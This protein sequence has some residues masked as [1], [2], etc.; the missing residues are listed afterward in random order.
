VLQVVNSR[1]C[2]HVKQ[3][4]I[5]TLWR[6][7]AKLKNSTLMNAQASQS[8]EVTWASTASIIFANV[9]AN[10]FGQL[11][12][13]V[14]VQST[15]IF[16]NFPFFGSNFFFQFKLF[17]DNLVNCVQLNYHAIQLSP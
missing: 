16:N 10:I 15:I 6:Y 12:Q 2:V 1:V 9:Q 13:S 3:T 7:N 11:H 4:S 5:S 8:V 14:A 17:T